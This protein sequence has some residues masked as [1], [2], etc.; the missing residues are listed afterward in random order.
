MAEGIFNKITLALLFALLLVGVY[1]GLK[2]VDSEKLLQA[3]KNDTIK[4]G[5]GALYFAQG[6]SATT[7]AWKIDWLPPKEKYIYILEEIP[8]PDSSDFIAVAI[9]ATIIFVIISHIEWFKTTFKGFILAVVLLLTSI[10]GAWVLWKVGM[11]YLY[12]AG[13]DSIGITTQ[14][15]INTRNSF[16]EKVDDFGIP[17]LVITFISALVVTKHTVASML[18]ILGK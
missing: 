14:E 13:C 7:P 11:Y 5:A 10:I 4:A 1:S 8:Y 12:F 15:C 18:K 2:N 3:V 6:L 16:L 9:I 17:I